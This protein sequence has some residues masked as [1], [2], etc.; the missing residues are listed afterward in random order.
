MTSRPQGPFCQSCG[1]PMES[2]ADFG[3]ADDGIRINDY[4][5]YC[6]ERG[7]F[8][9]PNISMTGM[10]DRCVEHMV[11][12]NIMPAGQARSLMTEFI[13]MLKRWRTTAAE[14]KDRPALARI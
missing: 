2:A 4:C 9:Q 13:P 12:Q 1:M 6:Y 10:I 7:E 8:T 14:R 3:T 11:R 5:R